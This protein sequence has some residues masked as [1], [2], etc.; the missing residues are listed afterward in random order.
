M[1]IPFLHPQSVKLE[2]TGEIGLRDISDE[3]FPFGPMSPASST[4]AQIVVKTTMQVT[5]DRRALRNVT[6]LA[7]LVF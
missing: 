7:C 4:E 5:H 6:D 2:L 1:D 3:Q